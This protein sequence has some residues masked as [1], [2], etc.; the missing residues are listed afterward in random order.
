MRQVGRDAH[1]NSSFELSLFLKSPLKSR[2]MAAAR[3]EVLSIDSIDALKK[4][5]LL[6]RIKDSW[7]ALAKSLLDS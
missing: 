3:S 6:R 5:R 1:S 7:K 2:Y 4:R